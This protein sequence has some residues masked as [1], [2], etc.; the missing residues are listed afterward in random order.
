MDQSGGPGYP[1]P[2]SQQPGSAPAGPSN[3]PP[4]VYPHRPGPRVS[5]P[6]NTWKW[7]LGIGI[8]VVVLCLGGLGACA[9]ITISSANKFGAE[10]DKA[11][12]EERAA[13]KADIKVTSCESNPDELLPAVEVGY[14]ITNSG[15]DK[16]SYL[17]TFVV[18]GDSGNRLGEAIE[19]HFD[20]N[21]GRSTTGTA[22][23]LVDHTPVGT[24]DCR[25][26][27]AI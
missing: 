19:S 24:F 8:A 27:D 20:L 17:I 14:T 12:D 3:P 6:N 23:V 22:E 2:P 18:D 11:I 5:A 26:A 25:V 7:L 16:R 21:P 13:K 4:S 9:A 1:Q 10:V 15:A